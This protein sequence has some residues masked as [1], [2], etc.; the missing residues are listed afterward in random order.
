MSSG[1]S[2]ASPII[3]GATASLLQ[4]AKSAGS[5]YDIQVLMNMIRNSANNSFNPDSLMGYGIPNYGSLIA[6]IGFDEKN[7]ED[8]FNLSYSED[9]WRIGWSHSLSIQ[10]IEVLDYTGRILFEKKCYSGC[11]D[12]TVPK[13]SFGTIVNV[14]A[15]SQHSLK[16]PP[17]KF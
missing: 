17:F 7:V 5:N 10:K 4:L 6:H 1:T 12:F 11:M 9:G 15:E 2:F 13:Y 16:I 3:C 14:L 8:L